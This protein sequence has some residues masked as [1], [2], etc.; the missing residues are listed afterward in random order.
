MTTLKSVQCILYSCHLRWP[1]R[2]ASARFYDFSAG[3]AEEMLI[4]AESAGI[5]IFSAF[6]AEESPFFC[7]NADIAPGNIIPQIP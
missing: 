1:D 4:L 5:Q 7:G 6:S 2:P 3:F